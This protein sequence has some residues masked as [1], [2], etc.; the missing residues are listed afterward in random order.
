MSITGS[1]LNAVKETDHFQTQGNVVLEVSDNL[2]ED[3]DSS[4][5]L[6]RPE[7]AEALMGNAYGAINIAQPAS[8]W[9]ITFFAVSLSALFIC[10]LLT[11]AVTRKTRVAG[12]TVPVEGS[13]SVA[14]PIAGVVGPMQLQEG[15]RVKQGDVLFTIA[16]AR[17]GKNGDVG[18]FVSQQIDARSLA[19]VAEENILRRQAR[20][21]RV[22]L[23]TRL[24]N[25]RDE[26]ESI[27]QQIKL[28]KRREVLAAAA[29]ARIQKLQGSGFVS[30]SQVEQKNEELL[31]ASMKVAE[32]IRAKSQTDQNVELLLGEMNDVDH[33]L[34]TDIERLVG[35]K[36]G[37]VQEKAQSIANLE[38][39][40]VAPVGG[41]VTGINNRSGQSVA[42]GQLMATIIPSP[43]CQESATTHGNCETKMEVNLFVPSRAMGFV[44]IGQDVRLRLDAYPFQK[45]GSVKGKVVAISAT[46]FGLAELPSHLQGT[47]ASISQNSLR[48]TGSESLYRIRVALTNQT[49]QIYDQPRRIGTNMTLQAD[50]LQEKRAIW[51][52]ILE[53]LLAQLR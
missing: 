48:Q 39:S 18:D 8:S 19:L 12:L 50:I 34:S 35:A 24:N 38:T 41:F 51:E 30:G 28:A 4:T 52:W 9:L 14:A 36:A 29:L 2:D 49:I 31:D 7:V 10:L 23:Q 13:V 22:H 53:P 3:L 6:F 15:V 44:A 47:I 11:G 25:M 21:S 40:V 20:D 45:F 27:G 17:H 33:R 46:P 16:S 5:P 32:L 26:L 43:T 1:A 42:A 37:L